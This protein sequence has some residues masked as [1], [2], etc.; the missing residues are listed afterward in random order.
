[1]SQKSSLPQSANS[2]SWVLTPDTVAKAVDELVRMS[3]VE[4]N[5]AFDGTDFL[6]VPLVAAIFGERKLTASPVKAS[7]ETDVRMLQDI[8]PTSEF[9]LKEG[10][11]PRV[12]SLFRRIA[13]RVSDGNM[14]I[15]EARPI[16]EFVSRHYSS[17]W[18]MMADLYEEHGGIDG[19]QESAESIRRFLEGEPTGEPTRQAWERLGE[20]YVQLNDIP[21]AADAHV[22]AIEF[23]GIPFS[24]ISN[25]ANWLNNHRSILV[26]QE[27]SERERLFKRVVGI[28][29]GRINEAT[30]T[31]LSRLAWLYLPRDTSRALALARDG[32]SRDPGNI[33]CLKL[34]ERLNIQG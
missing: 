7:I 26:E 23:S 9:N 4:R 21:S 13:A 11:R 19:L 22:R 5:P 24:S 20:L 3:L 30:A 1:M 29:E 32:L 31:D 18:L 28:M 25:T 10:I 27:P 16:L 34:V 33:H 6:G 2:V 12:T 15:E 8:G 14:T 17:G